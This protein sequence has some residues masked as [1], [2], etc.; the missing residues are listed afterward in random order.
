MCL[1]S[2]VLVVPLTKAAARAAQR[3]FE[4]RRASKFYVALVRGRV[5]GPGR[6][7]VSLPVGGDPDP[8][9]TGVSRYTQQFLSGY[10]VS[11][12]W[13]GGR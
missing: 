2:G 6:G 4:R 11:D 3:E 10:W 1:Q 13:Y 8:A 12:G 9:W 5:A 7:E